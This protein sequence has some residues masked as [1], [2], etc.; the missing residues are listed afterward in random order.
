MFY[1]PEIGLVSADTTRGKDAL[2]D[3]WMKTDSKRIIMTRGPDH[4]YRLL[5]YRWI[6]LEGYD[7]PT[8]QSSYT[9]FIHDMNIEY[10]STIR[11][12]ILYEIIVTPLLFLGYSAIHGRQVRKKQKE[13]LRIILDPSIEEQEVF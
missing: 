12:L 10:F 13:L 2:F 9:I 5:N 7:N 6:P 11:E 8:V 3:N 4:P 1:L